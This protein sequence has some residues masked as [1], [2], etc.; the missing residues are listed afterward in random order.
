M[1]SEKP[2]QLLDSLIKTSALPDDE[3]RGINGKPVTRPELENQCDIIQSMLK[4][5]SGRYRLAECEIK[6][7]DSFHIIGEMGGHSDVAR[8][9]YNGSQ[10][11]RLNNIMHS[12]R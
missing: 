3:L 4:D 12:N 10:K 6:K 7:D 8:G 9:Y 5:S 11:V 1:F 2:L